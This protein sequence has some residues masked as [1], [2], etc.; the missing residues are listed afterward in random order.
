MGGPPASGA[1]GSELPD[2]IVLEVGV[3]EISQ[4]RSL[5]AERARER[6]RRACVSGGGCRS[7]SCAGSWAGSLL[8]VAAG[9][10]RSVHIRSGGPHRERE[11]CGG[12]GTAM[13]VGA[14]SGGRVH[15]VRSAR[16]AGAP[17]P[18]S[19]RDAVVA[20][21]PARLEGVIGQRHGDDR[22]RAD[23]RSRTDR[24][25]RSTGARYRTRRSETDDLV[26]L[27]RRDVV[28]EEVDPVTPNHGDALELTVR[29]RAPGIPRWPTRH[30]WHRAPRVPETHPAARRLARSFPATVAV[31]CGRRRRPGAAWYR[32]ATTTATVSWRFWAQ[33][34]PM[35]YHAPAGSGQARS[36]GGPGWPRQVCSRSPAGMCVPSVASNIR[37]TAGGDDG[38]PFGAGFLEFVLDGVW[39]EKAAEARSVLVESSQVVSGYA[40]CAAVPR[41]H[42]RWL[43]EPSPRRS[44]RLSPGGES[45]PPRNTWPSARFA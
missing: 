29:F 1:L 14:T 39:C 2:L 26:P 21:P 11:M 16:S 19:D 28:A 6:R 22:Y 18:P 41:P 24:L 25:P 13:C 23:A 37:S 3:A 44:D 7:R 10:R 15:H 30:R 34:T 20:G 5:G 42:V 43:G 17:A 27:D 35:Q 31:G 40:A 12:E 9:K 32:S 33:S 45:G 8:V 4:G 36:A 38:A